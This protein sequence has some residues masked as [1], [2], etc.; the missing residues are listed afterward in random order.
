MGAS[1]CET[2]WSASPLVSC[3]SGSGLGLG[4]I[5]VDADAAGGTGDSLEVCNSFEVGILADVRELVGRLPVMLAGRSV[6]SVRVERVTLVRPLFTAI[7]A[8][9]RFPEPLRCCVRRRHERPPLLQTFGGNAGGST[10]FLALV[11]GVG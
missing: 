9:Q 6:A 10:E 11:I 5:P 4:D 7:R 2:C 1:I 3:G 8:R